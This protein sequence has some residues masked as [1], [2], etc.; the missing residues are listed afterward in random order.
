MTTK[1]HLPLLLI[2]VSVLLTACGNLPSIYSIPGISASTEPVQDNQVDLLLRQAQSAPPEQAAELKVQAAENLVSMGNINDAL[3]ILESIDKRRLPSELG[4]SIALQQADLAL[5]QDNPDRAIR[6]L[7]FRAIPSDL[8]SAQIIQL[9]SARAEAFK[10]FNNPISAARELISASQLTHDRTQ[11]QILH[12]SIWSIL[13]DTDT[14]T[15]QQATQIRDNNFFEQ[16]WFER[17]TML[18]KGSDFH[19]QQEQLFDWQ[20]LWD[21]HP[22]ATLPPRSL[23]EP[24]ATELQPIPLSDRAKRVALFLPQQ[25][26]LADF[27]QIISEGFA[28]AI[29][30][31][32]NDQTE[33]ILL[34]STQIHSPEQLFHAARSQGADFIVGPLERQ[35]VNQLAQFPEHPIPVLALNP[36]E[37]G[38]NPPMQLDLSSDHEAKTLVRRA[39][40]LGYRTAMIIRSDNRSGERFEQMIRTAFEQQGGYISATLN[41]IPTQSNAAQ[42][43]Q[44]L[45][46]DPE[47]ARTM[48][49]RSQSGMRVNVRHEVDVIFMATEPR[50]ARLIRPMLLY[51]FAGAIP[52]MATSQLYEGNPNASRDADLNGIQFIDIPWRLAKPSDTHNHILERRENTDSD[53]GKL[54]ALG[55]DAYLISQ[56]LSY[57][58]QQQNV[59]E[60]E[61]GVLTL[62]TDRRINRELAWA[63]F[64]N[65]IPQLITE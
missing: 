37:E 11:Q 26:N 46:Q 15:L 61:T 8:N 31:S 40:Q 35:F 63:Q 43:R 19:A 51:H 34:D 18:A 57:L 22:A 48:P 13:V 41:F 29:Q 47:I 32:G 55:A 5:Q 3:S 33:M 44:L 64:R 20:L 4:L 56:Q 24:L 9:N 23:D 17:A 65:G 7:D 53:I 16:G 60:G 42:V 54:Y 59:L 62:G 45:M 1:I 58:L 28:A 49:R 39:A 6:S 10:Q 14:G 36:A 27:S 38:L 2:L 30:S 21:Q 12:N 50:D 52:V 25:G